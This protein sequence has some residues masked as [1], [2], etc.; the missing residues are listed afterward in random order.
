L[1]CAFKEVGL[2]DFSGETDD[3]D[4]D[5]CRECSGETDDKHDDDCFNLQGFV[6]VKGET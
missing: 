6:S 4:M 5:D 3:E 1:K 2:I